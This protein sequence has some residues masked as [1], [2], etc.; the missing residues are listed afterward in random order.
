MDATS[1]RARPQGGPLAPAALP[2]LS[3]A[4]L[5]GL[6]ITTREVVDCIERHV[7]GQRRGTSW[8]APKVVVLPGDERYMMATLGVSSEHGLG[9][10]GQGGRRERPALRTRALGSRIH[11]SQPPSVEQTSA[12]SATR[13]IS[14]SYSRGHG[15]SLLMSAVRAGPFDR[16]AAVSAPHPPS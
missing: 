3:E 5:E 14:Q 6:A 7:V 13:R 2:F 12:Y 10:E 11:R 9:Q 8:C 16:P 1:E 4:V 15:S